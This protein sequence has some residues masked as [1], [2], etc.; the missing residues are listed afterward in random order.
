MKI[1][2]FA[3]RNIKEII[4]DPLSLIFLIGFP[5]VLLLFFQILI[6]SMGKQ[7]LDAT[8]QFRIDNLAGSIT[9]FGFSFLTLFTGMLI[10]K[11]RTTS[12]VT[13]L[14]T[15][16]MTTKDFI[17]GYLLPMLPIALTQVIICFLISL[18]FGLKISVNLLLAVVL[19][20]PSAV[21]FIAMG[22]LI[23]SVFSDKAVGGIASI[24]VNLATILGGMFFPL[25]VMQGAFVTVAYIFPF[26]HAVDL[27]S[28]AIN[29]QYSEILRP[30]LVVS[31]YAI[32]LLAAALLVFRKKLISDRN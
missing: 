23:G 25:R 17:F 18:I 8:P 22:V 5:V 24:I 13:R 19:L 16:P 21:M 31:L 28:F 3:K 10:A 6:L 32:V 9:I 30:L 15:T 1:T 11:D 2:V 7:I 29:G 20:L 26:A 14:R 4:R 12:F 27:A